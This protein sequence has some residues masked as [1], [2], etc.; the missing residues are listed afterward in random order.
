M[1][2]CSKEAPKLS[3]Q[4]EESSLVK[5]SKFLGFLIEMYGGELLT[6]LLRIKNRKKQ[7]KR[8]GLNSIT[9][10]DRELKKLVWLIN[11]NRRERESRMTKE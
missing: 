4:W 1:Q 3:D 6:L 8:K 9:K 10:V 5:F 11:Y 2:E 7:G